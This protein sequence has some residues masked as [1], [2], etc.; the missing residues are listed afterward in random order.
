[1]KHMTAAEATP[2]FLQDKLF[3]LN[4]ALA[5]VSHVRELLERGGPSN[6]SSKA[7]HLTLPYE[8]WLD[9]LDVAR[10]DAEKNPTYRFVKA[11]TVQSASNE[12]LLIRCVHYEFDPSSIKSPIHG[13]LRPIT[14]TLS[15]R[16]SVL[17]FEEYL[18]S[19]TQETASRIND[20]TAENQRKWNEVAPNVAMHWG[21]P[22][23]DASSSDAEIAKLKRM[24][25]P[26]SVWFMTLPQ[27]MAD[28]RRASGLY[29]SVDTSDVIAWFDSGNCH[30]CRNRR[31]VCPCV[32]C[33]SWNRDLSGF[34]RFGSGRRRYECNRWVPCPLCV[35]KPLAHELFE[36]IESEEDP[37]SQLSQV[38]LEVEERVRERMAELGYG[39]RYM[40]LKTR[41][42]GF[43]FV[44]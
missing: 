32:V 3:F 4:T 24:H 19:A 44:T 15:N 21:F 35:S 43:F 36:R 27:D 18:S 37:A 20:Q 29:H 7:K 23:D 16:A 11:S 8:V 40:E 17:A 2:A 33:R 14:G 22:L 10:A 1:M 5:A 13:P 30:V 6:V 31:F 28:K 9:I 41:T 12:T 38:T 34:C 39:G 25:G 42:L 26:G